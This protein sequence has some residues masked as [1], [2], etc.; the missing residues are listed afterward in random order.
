MTRQATDDALKAFKRGDGARVMVVQPQA[1]G[2]GLDMSVA[3]HMIWYSLIPSWV[4]YRQMMDRNALHQHGTRATF[5]IVPETVDQIL[6]DTLQ[7]DGD[8]S[9]VILRHPRTIL[10]RSTSRR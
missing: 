3:P 9:D 1:G 4:D 7:L 10:R 5:L 8:V 6:Y 2:M